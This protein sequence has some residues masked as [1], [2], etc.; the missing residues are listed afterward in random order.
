M[1]KWQNGLKNLDSF[2]TAV[3]DTNTGVY[4]SD[5]LVGSFNNVFNKIK[6]DTDLHTFP[7]FRVLFQHL[8]IELT[9]ESFA[10]LRNGVFVNGR[11][12]KH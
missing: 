4:L 11:V 1:Q 8:G 5:R 9:E 12:K 10:G 3:D 6:G 7:N 2:T